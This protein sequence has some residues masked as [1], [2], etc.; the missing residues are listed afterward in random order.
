M[1][2][3]VLALVLL[4]TALCLLWQRLTPKAQTLSFAANGIVEQTEFKQN[5]CKVKI[6]IYEWTYLSEGFLLKDIPKPSDRYI[7][8]GHKQNCQAL[9]V[10]M[11]GANQ[12]IS[13]EVKGNKHKWVFVSN[14]QAALNCGGLSIN[15]TPEPEG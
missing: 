3:R 9:P 1:K 10:A 4:S 14:P 2:A 11:S 13:F 7:V 15:W 12:H 8:H 5:T 6:A